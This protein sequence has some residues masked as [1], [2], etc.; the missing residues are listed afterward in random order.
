MNNF[1]ENKQKEILK[2]E[3]IFLSFD[4]KKTYVLKDIS[5]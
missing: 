5:F 2:I 1:E 3:N 4:N